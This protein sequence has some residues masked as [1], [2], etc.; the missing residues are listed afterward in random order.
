MPHGGPHQTTTFNKP[1]T[2][3]RPKGMPS[4]LSYSQPKKQPSKTEVF[5]KNQSKYK[6]DFNKRFPPV[7]KVPEIPDGSP[8][9][10]VEQKSI[11][12]R[13]LYR[14]YQSPKVIK[15]NKKALEEK[16]YLE[17]MED[18]G[19]FARVNRT[20]EYFNKLAIDAKKNWIQPNAGWFEK[21]I[22]SNAV[23]AWF[24]TGNT[25]VGTFEG[26]LGLTLD[27]AAEFVA[28]TVANG[29]DLYNSIMGIKELSPQEKDENIRDMT[30]F[31][32][33]ATLAYWESNAYGGMLRFPRAPT[34]SI[35]ATA[36]F[37]KAKVPFTFN[38]SIKTIK[39]K[40]ANN[41]AK[42]MASNMTVNGEF[43]VVSEAAMKDPVVKTE[44]KQLAIQAFEQSIATKKGNIIANNIANHLRVTNNINPVAP[45]KTVQ[46]KSLSSAATT[47]EDIYK[48]KEPFFNALE[49]VTE[50]LP[51]NEFN[52]IK[53]K[54]LKDALVSKK[55]LQRLEIR[56]IER[57]MKLTKF[58]DFIANLDA[59][60]I[61][62]VDK[63]TVT[64]YLKDNP[65]ILSIDIGENVV[66]PKLAEKKIAAEHIKD[67]SWDT[68]DY[69]IEEVSSRFLPNQK[70]LKVRKN[71][72]SKDI[73]K[74]H[75]ALEETNAPLQ[76]IKGTAEL[77]NAVRPVDPSTNNHL[78]KDIAH[79]TMTFYKEFDGKFSLKEFEEGW[80]PL[81]TRI[82]ENI[83]VRYNDGTGQSKSIT[84]TKSN[85]M[86]NYKNKIMYNL[87]FEYKW[88]TEMRQKTW[89]PISPN[90]PSGQSQLWP[91]FTSKQLE[92]G[93]KWVST[94][95][96]NFNNRPHFNPEYPYTGTLEGE[97]IDGQPITFEQHLGFVS[98]SPII[99]D[100]GM[101]WHN[102]PFSVE[103]LVRVANTSQYDRRGNPS[104]MYYTNMSSLN[105]MLTTLVYDMALRD[106]PE[107][108]L[109]VK[110]LK[111]Y[112]KFPTGPSEKHAQTY[113]KSLDAVQNSNT[114]LFKIDKAI[115]STNK[116]FV[117][118]YRY[119][120]PYAGGMYESASK[121]YKHVKYDKYFELK[122][123]SNDLTGYP[124]FGEEMHFQKVPNIISWSTNTALNI[125]KTPINPQGDSMM[126]TQ[127]IQSINPT[128]EIGSNNQ[129]SPWYGTMTKRPIQKN[130][131]LNTVKPT[132]NGHEIVSGK[133]IDME[134]L[135]AQSPLISQRHP[136]LNDIGTSDK[137]HEWVAK[138]DSVK[139][140]E[141][142]NKEFIKIPNAW[143]S[144]KSFELGYSIIPT[145]S[146]WY[147]D[148]PIYTVVQKKNKDNAGQLLGYYQKFSDQKY[149]PNDN[150]AMGGDIIANVNLA[151]QMAVREAGELPNFD[152]YKSEADY[153]QTFSKEIGIQEQREMGY[154]GI[155][156]ANWYQHTLWAM[157]RYA[158]DN[159]FDFLS[160]PTNKSI[161][162]KWRDQ[163]GGNYNNYINVLDKMGFNII[164]DKVDGEF[165]GV[166]MEDWGHGAPASAL[167]IPG[168]DVI[169]E[170]QNIEYLNDRVGDDKMHII[171]L[172]DRDKVFDILNKPKQSASLIDQTNQLLSTFA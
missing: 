97:I 73:Q 38:N 101:V 48:L 70:I 9:K 149:N 53:V 114:E 35:S 1:K 103:T 115:E 32:T 104:R 171:D 28:N 117:Y 93:T 76:T 44:I 143:T 41:K 161:K 66:P 20:T 158:F 90:E 118:P 155:G 26:A 122:L 59:N 80:I 7:P 31:I 43:K 45:L 137:F 60:N 67:T 110:S 123:T 6:E 131:E 42:N 172:R 107:W 4:F 21:T 170:Q 145:D 64:K 52:Q 96:D 24:S 160:I 100:A 58:D 40:M 164:S 157:T 167:D 62:N 109:F 162:F 2:D 65:I 72:A 37:V 54:D 56:K 144:E 85:V 49:R 151:D 50:S 129:G 119:S 68:V 140:E 13:K 95:L 130:F 46:A 165:V 29:N 25:I 47:K 77:V 27:P 135:I 126:V 16:L 99:S 113:Q 150:G 34:P 98:E 168:S 112:E 133:E 81:S 10:T 84:F 19:Y 94:I 128:T 8:P 120:K 55:Q 17:R 11:D 36:N 141:L 82:S 5:N 142:L 134:L 166:P 63:A 136:D 108:P 30:E 51:V 57:P 116:P 156:S 88:D 153:L 33:G 148:Q 78:F 124:T 75:S 102:Q 39:T 111:S 91:N 89:I 147:T 152:P 154:G 125:N 132:A 121:T 61:T 87:G 146:V 92:T 106:I 15:A 163:S 127:E 169:L 12:D 105:N 139:M 69:I 14:Q 3:T 79:N 18:T 86:E 23:D 159:G 71:T 83:P 138:Q 74:Y 22:K